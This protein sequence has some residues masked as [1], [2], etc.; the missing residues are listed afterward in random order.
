MNYDKDYPKAGATVEGLKITGKIPNLGSIGSTFEK[1]TILNGVRELSYEGWHP[2][3]TFYAADDWKRSKDLAKEIEA[4][5]WIDPLIVA[6]E[7]NEPYILEGAHRFVALHLLGLKSFPALIVVSEED[8][9]TSKLSNGRN[10]S[11]V[12]MSHLLLAL[13]ICQGDKILREY[14]GE[15][16]PHLIKA[17]RKVLSAIEGD[18]IPGGLGDDIPY[19]AVDPEELKLGIE[20]ELEHT[21]DRD[22]A[23]EIATR[24][25]LKLTNTALN[26]L[27]VDVINRVSR[28]DCGV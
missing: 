23:A 15:N 21:E 6:V 10:N 22:L 24:T 19:S 1:Y 20:V 14:S 4:N 16:I 28:V 26:R 17:I 7:K 5:G 3:T 12:P 25:G 2:E 18:K 27:V 11:G 13:R 8:T 9:V